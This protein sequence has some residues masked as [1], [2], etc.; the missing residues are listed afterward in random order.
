ME[1]GCEAS[2]SYVRYDNGEWLAQSVTTSDFLGRV[3]TSSR[4]GTGGVMLTTSN[5][6]NNAGILVQSINHDGSSVVYA[7]DE[8]N[9]R[10][11]TIRIGAGQTLD[12][13]P[14]SFTLAGVIALDKYMIDE[15]TESTELIE[16]EWWRCATSAFYKPGEN[17]L[18]AS[19]QRV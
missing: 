15:T 9:E 3:V 7:Y 17:V 11:A 13:D 19:V 1:N 14:Q 2:T 8:L 6:Y 16:G 4:A 12:F 18:T 5:V 10:V